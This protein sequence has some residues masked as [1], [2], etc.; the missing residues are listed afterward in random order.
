MC[1]K[2]L[3]RG[4]SQLIESHGTGCGDVQRVDAVVHGDADGIVAGGNRRV[5]KPV[6]LR[7]HHDGELPL[8]CEARIVQ[9]DGIVPQRHGRRAEAERVQKLCPALRQIGP[10]H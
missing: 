1:V 9:P 2:A 5:C 6:A 4:F 8:G 10:R 3:F 7:A